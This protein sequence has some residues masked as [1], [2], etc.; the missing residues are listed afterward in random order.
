MKKLIITFGLIAGAILSLM[1][2]FTLSGNKIDFENGKLVGY[3][4]MIIALSTIFFATKSFRD[5][6]LNGFISFGKAFKI[7]LGITL[8]ASTMYV[9]SWMIISD[10]KDA[11]FMEQYKTHLIKQAEESGADKDEI[12]EQIQ[13]MDEM[14]KLYDNTFFKIAITYTEILP[15]GLI[16]SLISAGILK[17]SNKGE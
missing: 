13:Q 10:G 3:L 17:K 1:M 5:K 9:A 4:T 8:I 7:G 16:I 12:E 11:E 14:S 15:I 6:N 2:V